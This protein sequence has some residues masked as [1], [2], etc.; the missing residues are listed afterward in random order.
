M[1]G[2]E[3]SVG[4]LKLGT[5]WPLPERLLR[6][7]LKQAKRVL[8]VEH[9]E[10]FVEG[11]LKMLTAE[12]AQDIGPLTIY[13]KR[14]GHINVVGEVNLDMVLGALSSLLDIQAPKRETDY[15]Q[16]AQKM[17]QH[18][19][20]PRDLTFCPGCPHRATFWSI[21][22]ALKL[23]NRDGFVAG[24]I[25][26]YT[27]GMGPA[28]YFQVKTLQSMGSGTGVASG[29]GNLGHLG[30]QQPVLCVCGDSTFFHTAMPALMN[31]VHNQSNF[32]ML[33]LDNGATAMTGFQPHP[34]SGVS[35]AGEPALAVNIES[36]CRSLG[37]RVEIEDPFNLESTTKKLLELLE[38]EGKVRVLILRRK[39]AQVKA[40]EGAVLYRVHIDPQRC[41][42][43]DC[44]CARFCARVFRCPAITWDTKM[45]KAGI[46]EAIC[47]GCGVCADICPQSA[48]IK[49]AA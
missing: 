15:S 39:C 26:C 4:I 23:D 41:I 29:F 11:E 9:I 31:G 35:A 21:K 5:I 6:E 13:G 48:I 12:M 16:R 30:F 28:G 44:G 25:G 38:D 10:P 19:V 36:I 3:E 8:V 1:L 7:H 46:D 33:I 45:G 37:V 20:P 2:V 32:T 47:N 24:D 14:S 42:G 17:M 18:E 43:E 34:G 22:N 40:R 49:E 27:L